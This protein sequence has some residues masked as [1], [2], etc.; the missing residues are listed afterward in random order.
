[1]APEPLAI[2]MPKCIANWPLIVAAL[3]M[4]VISA[5]KEFDKDFKTLLGPTLF[6]SCI[7]GFFF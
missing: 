4:L 2:V 3:L 6:L 5:V 7:Y 1:L